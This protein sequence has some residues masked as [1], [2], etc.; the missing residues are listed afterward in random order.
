MADWR[1]VRGKLTL[2][3]GDYYLNK[4]S[5]SEVENKSDTDNEV[6]RI[7]KRRKLQME[8]EKNNSE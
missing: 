4:A 1:I 8:E 7:K 5:E 2:K 6:Q 3:G